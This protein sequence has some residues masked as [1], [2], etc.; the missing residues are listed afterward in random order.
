MRRSATAHALVLVLCTPWTITASTKAQQIISESQELLTVPPI[1]QDIGFGD[2]VAVDVSS[3]VAVVGTLSVGRVD[4]FTR[5]LLGEY[6]YATTLSGSS[7]DGFGRCAV[8]GEVIAVGAPRRGPFSDHG[9]V[10]LYRFD[11]IGWAF[12]DSLSPYT[13][14]AKFGAS[15]VLVDD[16]LVAS[17]PEHDLGVSAHGAVHVYRDGASGWL[18]EAVLTGSSPF[19]GWEFGFS[20][21]S[22]G[23]TV[24]V[25]DPGQAHP[26]GLGVPSSS[27]VPTGSQI[28]SWWA[29]V[30]DLEL[31]S[32][33]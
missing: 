33:S 6:S 9:A 31:E 23:Q 19:E 32:T 18:E 12:E 14:E 28:K 4:V 21:A 15:V 11:G 13:Q 8:A 20:I 17:A 1:D 30:L 3:G 7:L 10:D 29:S 22:D 25:G 26:S 27:M 24:V 16:L 2:R 5:D